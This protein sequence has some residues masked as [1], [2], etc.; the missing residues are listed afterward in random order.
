MLHL[1][2]TSLLAPII[3]LPENISRVFAPSYNLL[4]LYRTSFTDGSQDRNLSKL[5]SEFTNGGA[6]TFFGKL[7]THYRRKIDERKADILKQR[8]KLREETEKAMVEKKDKLI[9]EKMDKYEA[10]RKEQEE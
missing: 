4:N 5:T 2:L 3:C 10:V 9:R 6:F 8:E 7:N 1:P